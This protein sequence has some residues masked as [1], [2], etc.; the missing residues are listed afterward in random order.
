MLG[1][2]L[3]NEIYDLVKAKGKIFVRQEKGKP[4][5]C[6]DFDQDS[7][8]IILSK[9]NSNLTNLSDDER[10]EM[11]EKNIIVATIGST[12]DYTEVFFPERYFEN[13]PLTGRPFLH[14]LFDCYTLIRDYYTRN[15]NLMMPNN[16]QREWE[17]WNQ[18][19]NL[20]VEN[21]NNYGFFEV[22]DIK[23]HDLLVMSLGSPVPNHGAVYLGDG[24]LIHHVAGRFSTI[25]ELST[26]YKTK[27]SVVYRNN[28][29]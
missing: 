22:N 16:M 28:T 29:I 26:F 15:F 2:S 27:I 3:P 9:D 21:A 1:H 11:N 14:G 4:V 6:E 8:A 18:G 25:E 23:K 10:S 20:Y 5:V 24:K 7:V 13:R 17:W 12:K 19:P